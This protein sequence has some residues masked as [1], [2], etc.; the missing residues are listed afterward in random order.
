MPN[1]WW[2]SKTP[3]AIT[4]HLW[5]GPEATAF[6]DSIDQPDW[7]VLEH[8]A[9][10][11]SLWFAKR[12]KWVMSLETKWEWYEKL[13]SMKGEYKNISPVYIDQQTSLYL[14]S[15]VQVGFAFDLFMLDGEPLE[16]RMAWAKRAGL[17]VKRGGWICFDNCNRE[18]FKEAR[19]YLR[20]I[21]DEVVTFDGNQKSGPVKT[22]YLVTEFYRLKA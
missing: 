8:G 12:C 15:V 7:N 3:N 18:E 11:S 17:F 2:H 10:G 9:G 1:E 13:M 19:A 22:E 14:R 16:D 4:P 20:S 6:L 5:L 21:A